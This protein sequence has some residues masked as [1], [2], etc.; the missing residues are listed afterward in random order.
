MR[1]DD[2]TDFPEPARY[3]NAQVR[4]VEAG[5]PHQGCH[6]STDSVCVLSPTSTGSVHDSISTHTSPVPVEI[7]RL[8]S[9]LRPS[10]TE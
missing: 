2:R 10:A 7:R 3:Q 1:K 4:V 9:A 8:L 6:E 5:A